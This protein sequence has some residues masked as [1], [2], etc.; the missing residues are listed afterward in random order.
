VVENV[1]VR[2][3]DTVQQGD[4]IASLVLK[5]YELARSRA[6][7]E[8]RAAKAEWE[9]MV[10]GTRKEDIDLAR[11]DHERAKARKSYW[12]SEFERVQNLVQSRAVTESEYERVARESDAAAQEE[13][14]AKA[15][16]E[17]ALAGNR[18]EE[19]AAAAAKVEALHQ[20]AILADRQKE[21]ATLKAPFTGRVERRFVDPGAFINVF[22]MGG[23]PV[24]QLVDLNRVEAAISV[25]EAQ[26]GRFAIGQNVE[27]ASAVRSQICATG[28]VDD[29]SQVAD[30]ASGTY[31]ARIRLPNP[32]GQFTGG[33]VVTA[34]AIDPE[35]RD[36]IRIPLTAIRR[37]HGQLPR[38]MLVSTGEGRVTEQEVELGPIHGDQVEILRGLSGGELL[39]VR[40]QHLVVAGDRVRHVLEDQLPIAQKPRTSP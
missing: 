39:V 12:Q 11:A 36:A 15:G 1:Y 21:K 6:I 3:G 14:M 19:I 5:D 31:L 18:K 32:D 28:Q 16:L 26:V 2:E 29:I 9:L 40:G 23:V 33:M 13:L 7:A 34:T 30:S 27:I 20:A 17:R 38:V 35:P 22:P 4:P 24:V 8:Y 25:P 10:A 37:A